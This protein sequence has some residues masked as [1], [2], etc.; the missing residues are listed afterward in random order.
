M[1]AILC[2]LAVSATALAFVQRWRN[3]GPQRASVPAAVEAFRSSST[4]NPDRSEN[5]PHPGV[6]VYVGSGV[7]RLSFMSTHQGQGPTMP[8]TVTRNGNC[9]SFRIQYNSFHSQSWQWCRSGRRLL[10]SGGV[11]T[12]KFDF[13]AFT[14]DETTRIS[15]TPPFVAFDPDQ[16][17]GTSIVTR[18]AG[19]SATTNVDVTTLGTARLV[20][21]DTLHVGNTRVPTL[22]YAADRVLSGDQQGTEHVEMWFSARD[23]FPIRN[24]R[25]VSA[26]S[27]APAPLN[28]V[29]YEERGSWQLSSFATQ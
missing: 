8:A 10:E 28:S 22:H 2:V 15:C 5:F 3:R 12:Q 24:E 11:T 9:W 27:P 20:G 26:V 13:A 29:T 6:Y 23:G 1:L 14:V 18:C 16:R 19:H 7:E 17:T 25:S 21:R 4:T